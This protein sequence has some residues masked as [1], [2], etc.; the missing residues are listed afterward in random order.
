[1]NSTPN[2]F[3]RLKKRISHFV[4]SEIEISKITSLNF[5][6]FKYTIENTRMVKIASR[7]ATVTYN[8][9]LCETRFIK[10]IVAERNFIDFTFYEIVFIEI[11][12]E[13]T[14]LVKFRIYVF[15]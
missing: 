5:Y 12:V 14:G 9:R 4:K 15:I 13:K 11:A 6:I 1:M 7:K 10:C 8:T 2:K 3:A